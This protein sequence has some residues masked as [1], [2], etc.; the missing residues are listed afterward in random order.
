MPQPWQTG[1]GPLVMLGLGFAAVVALITFWPDIQKE[2]GTLTKNPV[3]RRHKRKNE[4]LAGNIQG[5]KYGRAGKKPNIAAA[6]ERG[7]QFWSGFQ[8][9]FRDGQADR[10]QRAKRFMESK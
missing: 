7:K 3:R 2:A 4:W 6:K 10:R 9:G 8:T 1:V 5:R